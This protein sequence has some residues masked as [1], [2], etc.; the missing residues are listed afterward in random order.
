MQRT[1]LTIR[2]AIPLLLLF[3]FTSPATADSGWRFSL[4][5]YLWAT[6]MEGTQTIRG[7]EL[8]MNASFDEILEV[9]DY[10]IA[11]RFEARTDGW[12]MFADL[13]HAK[14]SDEA[15]LPSTAVSGEVR[16][17]IIEAGVS[18]PF[19]DDLEVYV[20]ARNQDADVSLQLTGTGKANADQS[21]TDGMVG[22]LWTPTISGNWMAWL[23][24]DV[25][26][27]DSD[28]VW[29]AATGVGYRFS[30]NISV[31]LG[32]RYLD[33]DYSDDGFGWD[34]AQSGLGLGVGI[35]W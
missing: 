2:V 19:S 35:H 4:T 20:G 33:T 12:G 1:R 30:E 13:F 10:G 16:Q 5:P 7:R 11:G 15:N 22:F 27:G 26:A 24:A 23:R 31:Q 34:I 3:G 9:L 17:T 21:W 14:L 32:Y 8:E 6:G 18:Y 28:S 29:L 25:G